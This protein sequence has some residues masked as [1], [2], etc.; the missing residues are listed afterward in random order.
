MDEGTV[1]AVVAGA[2][3]KTGG[4]FM[5]VSLF[6]DQLSCPTVDS[7]VVFAR[8]FEIVGKKRRYRAGI[9]SWP[10]VR[11]GTPWLRQYV[12]KVHI[13]GGIQV[14]LLWFA[15]AFKNIEACLESI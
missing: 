6:K 7:R 11:K 4:L 13:F 15:I 8:G 2:G 9:M 10:W 14:R 12:S 3:A 1:L 5:K